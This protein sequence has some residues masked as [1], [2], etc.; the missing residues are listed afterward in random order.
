MI[1][2]RQLAMAFS[3]LDLDRTRPV[4][5][6]ASLSA[7]GQVAG[8]P[9]TLLGAVLTICSG[10]MMPCFTYKTMVTPEIGPIDNGLV[11]GSEGDLNLM[12]EFFSL[13]LPADPLMGQIAEHLRQHP[14]AQRSIHPILSFAGIQV[15]DVLA[16]QTLEDPLAP[17]AELCKAGGYVLLLGVNHTANTSLHYAEKLAGRKQFVRWALTPQGV[18]ECPGFPGSSE[19]F[20]EVEPYLDGI[21]RRATVGNAR[22]QAI[23]LVE[24]VGIVQKL[25]ENNPLALLPAD[26]DDLRV[27]DARKAAGG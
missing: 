26:S 10:L 19:G 17:I 3:H 7:F 23:P 21:I 4:I 24:M 22:I 16:A 20:Q 2:Y 5:A 18:V 9:E 11:Y 6:H 12:A 1:T 14:R 13:T 27:Q 25:I 8:G 15:E